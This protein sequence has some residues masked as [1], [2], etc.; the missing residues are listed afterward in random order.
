M[1]AAREPPEKRRRNVVRRCNSRD[2]AFLACS[3]Q[4]RSRQ[5]QASLQLLQR[6]ADLSADR[7]SFS[8]Q[9]PAKNAANA[10]SGGVYT[11][12]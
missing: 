12:I 2:R 4:R 8:R 10:V 1:R 3:V 6:I 7:T 9:R 5:W 11:N